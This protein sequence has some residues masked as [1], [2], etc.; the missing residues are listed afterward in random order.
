MLDNCGP[1]LSSLRDVCGG[2]FG[3]VDSR[4]RLDCMER[5]VIARV[6]QFLFTCR[7]TCRPRYAI[8]PKFRPSDD[9]A[10]PILPTNWLDR[11]MHRALSDL[12]GQSRFLLR[13]F[14]AE[15]Q[16]QWNYAN[17]SAWKVR[18]SKGI[19]RRWN[20]CL[21]VEMIWKNSRFR[22]LPKVTWKSIEIIAMENL[23]IS[24]QYIFTFLRTIVRT[25]V[26]YPWYHIYINI[27]DN[28]RLTWHHLYESKS[29][30]ESNYLHE[31]SRLIHTF[32]KQALSF[33]FKRLIARKLNENSA[34][35]LGSRQ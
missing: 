16:V 33:S 29:Y 15:F 27:S 11:K 6:P 23:R 24:L 25:Y 3:P 10:Y 35:R 28:S 31:K 14:V 4:I 2:S 26:N 32:T 8:F 34:N 19:A 21:S 7:S 9:A 17:Y 20:S 13:D 30:Q 12:A 1:F 18:I 22:Y 5:D